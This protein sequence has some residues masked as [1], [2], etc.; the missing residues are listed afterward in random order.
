MPIVLAG[1]IGCMLAVL[2][3]LGMARNYD[4]MFGAEDGIGARRRGKRGGRGR[5]GKQTA[6]DPVTGGI[7]TARHPVPSMAYNT[8]RLGNVYRP[9]TRRM[10]KADFTGST[11]GSWANSTASAK[12]LIGVFVC[13]Q[14]LRVIFPA[15]GGPQD[16][17][18]RHLVKVIP[19]DNSTTPAV[20]TTGTV[21]MEVVDA[22]GNAKTNNV[23]LDDTPLQ[24]MSDSDTAD[25]QKKLFFS[26]RNDIILGGGD[27]LYVYLNSDVA[28]AMVAANSQIY[29]DA[30]FEAVQN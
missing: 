8:D 17:Y 22:M 3:M 25:V 13:P 1:A 5:S 14:N 30:I 24:T 2:A 6:R 26:N 11:G 7:I 15:N 21:R 29:M 10:T 27:K 16:P 23:L 20:I 9:I 12:S 28:T 4:E 18:K 19:K